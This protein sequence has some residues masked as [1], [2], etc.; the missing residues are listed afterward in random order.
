MK[1]KI[2]VL[3]PLPKVTLDVLENFYEL[4]Y[5][6]NPIHQEAL[7]IEKQL[8]E[9]KAV[10]TNGSRGMSAEEMKLF[11]NLQIICIY[12]AGYENLD[13][14]YAHQM[15]IKTTYAPGANDETVADHALGMMLCLA[16]GFH[17]IDPL[18]K[19][20]EWSTLR[21]ERPTLNSSSIGIVGL[22]NIGSKIAQR[23]FAFGMN[24]LYHTPSPKNNPWKYCSSIHELAEKVNYLVIACPGG[25]ETLHMVNKDVLQALGHE[26]YLI[27][28]SRGSVVDTN[29]LIEAL[30]H[31]TI[32][33]AALD[34]FENEP[35]I[36]SK[37]LGCNNILLTP[38]ISGRSPS[39]FKVQTE[40]L[41][42]NL[43]NQ[44]SGQALIHCI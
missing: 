10:I 5:A 7:F 17:Q 34:V 33:G 22:G 43:N 37:L 13:I 1:N 19:K 31:G 9:A 3:I 38:H 28:I 29:A 44:F 2:L 25:K 20:G 32:A 21:K 23:A 36:D 41:I 8:I 14:L 4:L 15:N 24:I 12:G 39:A 40:I 11:P 42:Y 18:V 27:N 35:Q 6:P 16:R 30:D 26:A